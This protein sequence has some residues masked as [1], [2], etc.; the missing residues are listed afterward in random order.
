[1]SP[2]CHLNSFPLVPAPPPLHTSSSPDVF[3]RRLLRPAGGLLGPQWLGVWLLS[4]R[5]T[6]F[7]RAHASSLFVI[8]FLTHNPER[9]W[10]L[11]C[12][13]SLGIEVTRGLGKMQPV[14]AKTCFFSEEGRSEL[15]TRQSRSGCRQSLEAHRHR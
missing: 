3:L 8:C 14:T 13:C 9:V 10:L 2:L 4:L 6:N 12:T 5:R 11:N 1:M 15:E 7:S